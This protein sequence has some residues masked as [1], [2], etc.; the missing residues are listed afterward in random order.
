VDWTSKSIDFMILYDEEKSLWQVGKTS[1]GRFAV[2]RHDPLLVEPREGSLPHA[3]SMEFLLRHEF[4]TE[5]EAKSY[6]RCHAAEVA[7]KE[8]FRDRGSTL[9]RIEVSMT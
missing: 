6:V 2:V 7:L 9:D 1:G 4:S 8:L 3:I 5:A